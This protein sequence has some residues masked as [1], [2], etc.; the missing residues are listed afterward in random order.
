M[1]HRFRSITKFAAKIK[2][3]SWYFRHFQMEIYLSY[4]YPE[5]WLELIADASDGAIIL[6][7]VG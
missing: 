1:V 3:Y 2:S 4:Y 6:M 5:I 7:Q